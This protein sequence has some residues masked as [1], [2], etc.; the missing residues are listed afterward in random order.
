MMYSTATYNL[1]PST[2]VPIKRL[3]VKMLLMVFEKDLEVLYLLHIN[4][5]V[6]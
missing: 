5:P 2:V 4:D 6:I 3:V 1:H